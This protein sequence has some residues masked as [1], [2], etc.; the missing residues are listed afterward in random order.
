MVK[1]ERVLARVNSRPMT[2][3]IRTNIS[4]SMSGEAIQNAMTGASGTPEA[5]RAAMIGTTPQEQNGDRAPNSAATKI[6]GPW[7]P[8]NTTAIWASRPVALT[9]A[10][11]STEASRK[12]AMK[13]RGSGVKPRLS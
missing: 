8:L 5:S 4:G 7:R 1:A 3:A 12:G 11:I 10:A 2:G 13:T 6:T 9:D